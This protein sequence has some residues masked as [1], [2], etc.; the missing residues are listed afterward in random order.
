MCFS[1]VTPFVPNIFPSCKYLV[2]AGIMQSVSAGPSYSA[3]TV[4]L[5]YIYIYIYIYTKSQQMHYSDG[6][7]TLSLLMSY[8]YGAPS[9]ARNLMSYIYG[10]DL[11]PGFCFFN[12]AFR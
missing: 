10:R 2:A 6:L 3:E 9:K 7:L 12:C 8:I 4:F 5:I 11:L 1:S